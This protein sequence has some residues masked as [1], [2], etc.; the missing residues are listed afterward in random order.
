MDVVGL[1]GLAEAQLSNYRRKKW[2]EARAS[3]TREQEVHQVDRMFLCVCA[4]VC[5][6]VTE[7]AGGHWCSFLGARGPQQVDGTEIKTGLS[8]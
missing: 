4:P 1:F 2:S 3:R 6:C 7:G 8:A 5:V